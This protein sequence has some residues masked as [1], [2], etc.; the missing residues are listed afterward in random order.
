MEPSSVSGRCCMVTV[1]IQG[2]GLHPKWIH[3]LL[4]VKG[5]TNR[6]EDVQTAFGLWYTCM[7][8]TSKEATTFL[9]PVLSPPLWVGSTA[10]PR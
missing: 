2:V 8:Q 6:I 1:T 10:L 9:D 3:D 4:V 5:R 7:L